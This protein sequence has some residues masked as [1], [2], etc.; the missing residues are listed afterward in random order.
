MIKWILSLTIMPLDYPFNLIISPFALFVLFFIIIIL[1]VILL[2]KFLAL[3]K[4][5]AFFLQGKDAKTLEDT[6]NTIIVDNKAGNAIISRISQ[7]QERQKKDLS[8]SIKKIGIIRFNPFNN[9]GGDQSFAIALLNSEN[10]GMIISS[11]FMREGG[12]R[13]YAKPIEKLKSTYQ[14]SKEEE[15]AISK[16]TNTSS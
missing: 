5:L 12:T 4:K 15:E 8:L 7:E 13:I 16:A 9:T 10:S 1:N 3:R 2:I 6:I 14:L 11:L